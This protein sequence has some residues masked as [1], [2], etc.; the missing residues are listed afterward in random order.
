MGKS[1]APL[2]AMCFPPLGSGRPTT[3]RRASHSPSP[4]IATQGQPSQL[5]PST[6]SIISHCCAAIR[7]S[8]QPLFARCDWLPRA[9]TLPAATRQSRPPSPS[10]PCCASFTPE[11]PRGADL[12]Q[13]RASPKHHLVGPFPT[14]P[15]SRTSSTHATRP[16]SIEPAPHRANPNALTCRL[17]PHS[18]PETQAPSPPAHVL[19]V[20]MSHARGPSRPVGSRLDRPRPPC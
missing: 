14:H 15:S 4:A 19:A 5:H 17:P 18:R 12:P 16:Q 1:D 20:R 7:R 3:L 2:S 10:D 8:R 13:P 11:R 6:T 9:R